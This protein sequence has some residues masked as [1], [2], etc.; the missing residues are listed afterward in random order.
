MYKVIKRDGKEVS[1]NIKKISDAVRKA[2]DACNRQ[3]EDSVIDMIALRVASDFEPK[4]KDNLIS[5]EDIQDS[6]EK[7]LMEAGFP[8]V[9]KAYILYRK[10]RESIR[11]ITNTTF[12]YKLLVD[13]Y[14]EALDLNMKEN[15]SEDYS[16]GG[17]ILSNSGAITAN[18][19][20]NEAYDEEI[21]NAHRN[22]DI[23]IHDL[24]MLTG[25]SAGWSI[26]QLIKE[27][28]GGVDGA[29]DS[30]PAESLN[31]LCIQL[32]NFLSILQNEWAGAQ[33]ISSFDTYLAP[34]IKENELSYEEVKGIIKSFV[35]SLNMPSRWGGQPPFTNVLFDWTVP[36]DLAKQRV[37]V[38]G[39]EL[40]YTYADCVEEIDML[41]K[42]F[43]E[44]MLE[45]DAS[46]KQFQYPI[47][48]YSITKDFNWDDSDNNSLLF[49]LATK[50]GTPF[51]A[52]YLNSVL[53]VGDVRAL[54]NKKIDYKTIQRKGG[55]Y[56]GSGENTGSIG[57][58]TV[59]LPRIAYQA[60]NEKDFYKRLD[61]IM[62][63]SARALTTK[64]RVLN[65][66]LE[67]GLYPFTKR[68]LKNFD[69]HFST[70]G[71][72]GMNE[73]C[74]NANW[75]GKDLT[76]QESQDFALEVLKH[77][78]EKVLSLQQEHKQLFALEATPAEGTSYRLAKKDKEEFEDIITA[79]EEV[80]YY[81]NSTYLPVGYT[82]DLFLALDIQ[83]KLQ[84]LYTSATVFNVYLKERLKSNNSTLILIRKIIGNYHFPY[85]TISPT[86]SVCK[87]HGYLQG[88]VKECP[89]CKKECDIYSRI[90]GYYRPLRK[91][92]EGKTQEYKD[93]KVYKVE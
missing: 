38:G 5:V 35:Y 90:T 86:Y 7:V 14:L 55:G 53:N 10:Q 16:V 19:W 23:H 15:K 73:A 76:N 52:N 78:Q 63:I 34:Y 65:Q 67:N 83:D 24:N 56:F 26:I 64:R 18:Y 17:L 28:L 37:V 87:K 72:I 92:N 39:K 27:G 75:L 70:I 54:N 69:Q 77:I 79:S 33:S 44:V 21:S 91:W 47:P 74:L 93:R 51:F 43:L 11:N 40:K 88:E 12:D 36:S 6:A 25:D 89:K 30:A 62:D 45:G 32:A 71:I 4:I 61:R 49:E 68:Y 58:V 81:T 41:N 57:S 20:L 31:E 13:R 82:D 60:K 22:A 3:Y 29:V 59:N 8:D 46:N 84:P 85:F 48:T 42:A 1:F 9:S 2:F 80:P 50:Y 66:L